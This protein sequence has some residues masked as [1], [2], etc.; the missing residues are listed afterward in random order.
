MISA[1]Q[2][3]PCKAQ[4]HTLHGKN[5][6]VD[7]CCETNSTE[8]MKCPTQDTDITTLQKNAQE[9]VQNNVTM[10]GYQNERSSQVK[11]T[12]KSLTYHNVSHNFSI[13]GSSH[14]VNVNSK[15]L[16]A[17]INSR[18]RIKARE[19]SVESCRPVRTF[20][21]ETRLTACELMQVLK[22]KEVR[23][24]KNGTAA[25][26]NGHSTYVSGQFN[27][28]KAKKIY[29]SPAQKEAEKYFVELF[30]SKFHSLK[31]ALAQDVLPIREEVVK[32]VFGKFKD[33]PEIKAIMV[34][35]KNL[36]VTYDEHLYDI[37]AMKEKV[38]HH[39]D[40]I[41]KNA[42]P[43]RTEQLLAAGETPEEVYQ[44]LR[45][46]HGSNLYRIGILAKRGGPALEMYIRGEATRRLK[47]IFNGFRYRMIEIGVSTK[48]D[49]FL[50]VRRHISFLFNEKYVRNRGRIIR[51][52]RRTS[53]NP[54]QVLEEYAR[55]CELLA[56][57][58]FR[59]PD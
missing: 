40:L 4:A 3:K 53:Y 56:I 26:L 33:H 41:I 50:I 29:S 9:N 25:Q 35:V 28:H 47:L 13:R 30:L 49:F 34:Y 58:P 16:R 32:K 20:D 15:H 43:E 38:D 11:K 10:K 59:P 57:T 31:D 24:F 37:K 21:D 1:F 7:Y 6:F 12:K 17:Q 48:K 18:R 2:E 46:V 39:I 51:K 23:E 22:N 44:I 54:F 45:T 8:F 42:S 55:M 36:W 52:V 19:K 14:L 27:P 5:F